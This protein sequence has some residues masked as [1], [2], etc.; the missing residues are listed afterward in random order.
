MVCDDP[1]AY[2]IRRACRQGVPVVVLSPGLFPSRKS[3]EE[4]LVRI[5]KTQGVEVVA[6]AGFMRILTPYFIRAF[7]GRVLNI[8]PSL[9]PAFKGA[10]AIRDAFQARVKH[11]GV[12]VHIVTE[13]LDSGPVLAQKKVSV[14]ESDTLKKLESKIHLAEHR[15]YPAAIQKFIDSQ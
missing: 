14:L 1:K 11:T 8:H 4:L 13:K 5:L 9:L 15:L 12:T 2:A 10:H 3:Y 6:L 7:R